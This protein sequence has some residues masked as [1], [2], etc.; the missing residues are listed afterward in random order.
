MMTP[1]LTSTGLVF[2][3][4]TLFSFSITTKLADHSKSGLAAGGPKEEAVD[5]NDLPSLFEP[6][7]ASLHFA[8]SFSLIFLRCMFVSVV[9][10]V[11]ESGVIRIG[12]SACC[13]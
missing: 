3:L 4:F 2:R 8:A 7:I 6:G 13:G 12:I 1:L 11:V 9:A 5:E 10:I